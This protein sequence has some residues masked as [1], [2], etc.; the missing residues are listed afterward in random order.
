MKKILSVLL[1]AI[2]VCSFCACSN[3]QSDST[4]DTATSAQTTTAQ[5]VKD[6]ADKVSTETDVLEWVDYAEYNLDEDAPVKNI[7]LMIGDG[8]GENI[9]KAS[10]VVKGDKLVMSGLKNKT[11]VTTY[12]QSV[13]DGYA[14]F[15]DSAASATA[16]STGNKTY[17]GCIGV[18]PDGN[19][20]ETICEFAQSLGLK[21]GLVDRHYVC[22][23]TPAGMAAH[24]TSRENYPQILR[25]MIN[26]N[27]NVMFGGGAKYYKN[28]K[29][30]QS[31][32]DEKGYKYITDEK[33]L[34]ELTADDDKVL[35]MFAY[36]NM[37][38]ADMWPSLTTMTSKAIEMLDSDNG[39]FLMVEGSNIDVFESEE[40]MDSTLEQMQAF[41]HSVD[42]VLKWAQE[43]PGT[44]VIVTADHETGGVKLPDN[45]K[46]E[47]INNSCFT[48]DGE[49]TNTNVL[50]MAGGAQSAGI[51]EKELID[52][53]DIAKY[54]RKVLNDS[55]K[56]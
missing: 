28:S 56:N 32:V 24:N 20:L 25:E 36:D 43:H 6:N 14:E 48:S 4:A 53:T 27:I 2:M 9:I 46:P 41:D 18:D 34:L 45:P 13:S 35:G 23:A 30:V 40:D 5:S 16:I 12:S 54:M 10:E 55:H 39:F 37:D 52:N 31:A 47:D 42:Y 22:H 8:M 51:C 19:K 29:K 44:L 26:S 50:L 33:Q 38:K 3:F 17:N 1:S 11:H 21:T 7:I 49:H 15:T